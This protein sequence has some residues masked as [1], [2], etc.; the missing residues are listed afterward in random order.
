MPM[1]ACFALLL[2]LAMQTAAPPQPPQILA[3][4]R[5]PLKPGS[6]AAYKEI[7]ENAARICAE[8]GC[9]HPY[10][11]IESL[12]GPKEVWFFNGYASPEELSEVL[13]AY[14]N[15]DKLLD[16]LNENGKRKKKLTG[17]HLEAFT[18]YRP[19]LSRGAPWI[20]GHGRFLVIT[21]TKSKDNTPVDG[22][23][24]EAKDHTRYIVTPFRTREEADAAALN[25]VRG[26]SAREARAGEAEARVF[27]VRP[28]WS[29]PAKEWNDADP[30]FWF[31]DTPSPK[32]RSD[33]E[34]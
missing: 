1:R 5:E 19:D 16:A 31:P 25:S 4:Y 7:E 15:N 17:K 10:L 3:I 30:F 29:L 28:F 23:V 18:N 2:G 6:E 34:K 33:P 14:A 21:V 26:S 12:T 24:Y 13:L 9:P 32:P 11:G 27:A 22:T 20:L 8:L